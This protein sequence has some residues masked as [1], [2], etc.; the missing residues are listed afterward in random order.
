MFNKV[1][2]TI[3]GLCMALLLSGCGRTS[4]S[5]LYV[6]SHVDGSDTLSNSGIAIAIDPVR[7]PEHLERSVVISQKT[8]EQLHYSEGDRWGGPLEDN[9]TAVIRDNLSTY[10]NSTKVYESRY[11]SP[12]SPVVASISITEFSGTLGSSATLQARWVVSEKDYN[13]ASYGEYEMELESDSVSDYVSTLSALLAK[14][15]KD[16]AEDVKD[17]YAGREDRLK[18]S[19]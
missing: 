18:D 5:R 9:I 14:L 2:L 3:G 8:K 11:G 13:E 19:E 4:P 6:L 17:F 12:Y 16:I 10:L 15:S 7:I 1:S